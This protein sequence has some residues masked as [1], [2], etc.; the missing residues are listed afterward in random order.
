M[1]VVDAN[2]LVAFATDDERATAVASRLRSWAAVGD[3]LHA[4]D[5]L[6]YE[7]ASALARLVAAR[8]LPAEEIT[9]AW[10]VIAQVPV[11]YHPLR[12]PDQAVQIALRL[13]PKSAYDAAYLL[14][15]REL[16]A[17]LWTFDGPLSR[18]AAGLGFPVNLIT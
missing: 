6:R 14:L 16:N 10:Q 8:M 9:E 12:N 13:G 5:L 2:V 17:E 3:T 4:P 18:N 1:I 7:A 15:A 11:T